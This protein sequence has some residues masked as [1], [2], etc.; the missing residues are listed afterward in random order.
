M[1]GSR[2]SERLDYKIY[3]ETGRK[4]FKVGRENNIKM[5]PLEELK[6]RGDIEYSLNIYLLSDL[7]SEEEIMEGITVLTDLGQKF[8]HVHIDLK[9]KLGDKY[10][11]QYPDHDKISEQVLN[12]VKSAKSKAREV[13]QEYKRASEEEQKEW[14]MRTEKEKERKNGK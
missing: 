4:Q 11:S 3:H 12:F 1:S 10:A 9:N 2:R 8:R 13:R 6:I 14:R 7:T 5:D